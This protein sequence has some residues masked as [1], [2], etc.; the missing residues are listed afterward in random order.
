MMQEEKTRKDDIEKMIIDYL[1]K[2]GET[3]LLE[4][5][6]AL[7]IG[8]STL[9]YHL[10]KLVEKNIVIARGRYPAKYHINYKLVDPKKEFI[11]AILSTVL[12]LSSIILFIQGNM[13]QSI[14]SAL[15]G[16]T[17]SLPYI[18]RV[19]L[20]KYMNK[21]EKLLSISK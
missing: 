3:K 1:I 8:H 4:L 2:H 20:D 11:L 18:W 15:I 10:K 16:L 17:V 9:D 12:Y 21:V 13:I 6:D 19:F 7:G 5:S 14:I